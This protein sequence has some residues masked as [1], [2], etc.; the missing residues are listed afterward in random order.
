MKTTA[1]LLLIGWAA[2]ASSCGQDAASKKM[3][4]DTQAQV[5]ASIKQILVN[6]R[7]TS[8]LGPVRTWYQ[9]E[10]PNIIKLDPSAAAVYRDHATLLKQVATDEPQFTS[11]PIL[12]AEQSQSIRRI[13]QKLVDESTANVN[14]LTSLAN[15]KTTMSEAEQRKF[16]GDL[17]AKEKHQLELTQYF[18]KRTF[19][20][21]NQATQKKKSDEYNLK[22]YGHY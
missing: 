13:Y 3:A 17:A 1:L 19:F 11:A 20:T 21:V 9:S 5:V 14:Q 18:S 10:V 22:T 12:T 15:S 16:V 2:L 6:S 7:D 8:S 4:A